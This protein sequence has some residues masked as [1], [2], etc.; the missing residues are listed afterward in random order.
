MVNDND[1]WK[2]YTSIV[3]WDT[4]PKYSIITFGGYADG[5]K[6]YFSDDGSETNISHN[7]PNVPVYIGAWTVENN[8]TYIYVGTDIGVFKKALL[9]DDTWEVYD[10]GMPVGV[11]ISDLEVYQPQN[12]IRAGTFGR[13]LWEAKLPCSSIY[14]L[15]EV[16]DPDSGA[17]KLQFYEA[18]NSITSS[19]KIIGLD[20]SVTY[21]AGNAI[22][23]TDGFHAKSGNTVI[24][25][26]ATCIDD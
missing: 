21:K 14:S 4:D 3:P 17:P 11:R 10:M 8:I 26:N 23:L 2:Y 13:G 25:R 6:V 15:T 20:G 19:R 9:D 16:N 7:L 1:C 24:I 12:I 18:E 5:R 22:F